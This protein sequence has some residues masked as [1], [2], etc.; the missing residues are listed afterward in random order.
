M[1]QA[2]H[3]FL[4]SHL[5]DLGSYAS[6]PFLIVLAQGVPCHDLQGLDIFLPT[7]ISVF[8][9]LFLT[10]PPLPSTWVNAPH[11][12]PSLPILALVACIYGPF[13]PVIIILAIISHLLT[14]APPSPRFLF[15][16]VILNA[17]IGLGLASFPCQTPLFFGK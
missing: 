16:P 15:Y 1:L 4:H 7:D 17:N 11:I 12:P 13:C 6:L 2:W 8:L 10:P 14:F 3:R 9:P 5:Y